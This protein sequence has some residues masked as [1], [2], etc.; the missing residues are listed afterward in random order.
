[1]PIDLKCPSCDRQ[2]RVPDA[3]AGKKARCPSCQTVVTIPSA[4]APAPPDAGAPPPPPPQQP[5]SPGEAAPPSGSPFAGPQ[6]AGPQPGAAPFGA[7][8]DARATPGVIGHR[9]VDSG[10]I[11]NYAWQI[12]QEN[13]G[14]EPM[15]EPFTEAL[16][17]LTPPG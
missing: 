7:G 10:S 17:R 5:V 14:L 16:T 12:W 11:I 15:N 1:M 8:V 13:L 3:A 2:L 6:A 9:V 4:S